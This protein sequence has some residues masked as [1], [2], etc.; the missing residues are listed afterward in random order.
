LQAHLREPG[1]E[2]NIVGMVIPEAGGLVGVADGRGQGD[3]PAGG[4]GGIP[5]G[6][7]GG[8]QQ[9]TEEAAPLWP[10]ARARINKC[11]SSL[12]TMRYHPTR[13]SLCRYGCG[14]LWAPMG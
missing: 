12:T 9:A 13:M 5:T 8:S 2:D 14:Y 10:P 7:R 6:G 11:V 1:G 4:H 3:G